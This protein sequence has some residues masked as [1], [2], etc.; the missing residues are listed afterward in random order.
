[1]MTRTDHLYI[2]V[3]FCKTICA[4]CDFCHAV[5]R[6]ETADRWLERLKEDLKETGDEEYLTI[7]IGG[8]TPS[9]L[10]ARQ[11]KGLLDMVRPFSGK[12]EE[13]TVEINPESIDEEKTAILKAYGINRVSIGLQSSQ[14]HLLKLMNRHHSYEDVQR[15]VEM[16]RKN[17]IYNISLD[18]LYSLPGQSL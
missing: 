8:G 11:L 10:N 15:A 12:T 5:Y 6:E 2:H 1:M 3:P 9:C 13:Y 16:F 7:Y 17:G 4:Y 18:I 14:K